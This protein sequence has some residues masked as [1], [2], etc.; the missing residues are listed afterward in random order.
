MPW[1]AEARRWLPRG[2][3]IRLRPVASRREVWP[4]LAAFLAWLVGSLLGAWMVPSP[5]G[6]GTHKQLRLPACSVME[7]LRRPCPGCGLTTSVSATLH[8]RLAE[9]FRA[10]PFGPPL[11]ALA[12]VGAWLAFW[13]WARRLRLSLDTPGMNRAVVAVLGSFLLYGLIRFLLGRPG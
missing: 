11:Y 7:L 6:H 5:E 1:P 10:H 13:A 8:G 2:P 12:T 3:W 4:Q 9:A